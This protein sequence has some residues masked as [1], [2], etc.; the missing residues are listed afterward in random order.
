MAQDSLSA[1]SDSTV[2]VK[3]DVERIAYNTMFVKKLISALKTPHSFQFN[4]DSLANNVSFLKSP[5]QAFRVITWS[6]PFADGSYKFYGTIQMATKNGSLKLIPLNDNTQNFTDDNAITNQKNWF[7]ARYYEI[8]PVTYP[9]KNPYYVLLGWKGNN[10]KTTKKVIEVLSFEKDQAIF[11]KSIFEI[12]KKATNRNRMVFEYNKMN[13]MTLTFDKQVNMI[14]FDH[15]APYENNMEG[16]MEY[17]VSDSSF[18]GYSI[19]YPRLYFKENV[20]LRNDAS[21][22]DELYSPPRKATTLLQKGKH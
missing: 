10:N 9:G 7:G 14:V 15:L 8:I 6:L 1:Y 19:S 13:S 18:D 17:Y 20:E 12:K 22:L 16:N 2:S 3:D 21:S 4:F 11:G 5:N